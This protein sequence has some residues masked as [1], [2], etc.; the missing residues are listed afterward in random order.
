MAEPQELLDGARTLESI[1]PGMQLPILISL[2]AQLAGV[3]ADPQTL[4][5]GAQCIACG[6]PPGM[7]VA[8]LI[9]LL[10][11]AVSGGGLAG[12]TCSAASDP[13]DPPTGTCG[14]FYRKDTGATWIWDGAA[15]KSVIAP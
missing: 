6:I 9:S 1:P 15:W 10:S 14:I 8:V 11:Q 4:I 12:V 3:S 2:F 13:V 7:Q 5:D